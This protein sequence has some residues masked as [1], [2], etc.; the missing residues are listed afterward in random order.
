MA[1]SRKRKK[2][3]ARVKGAESQRCYR[4]RMDR[5]SQLHDEFQGYRNELV[6]RLRPTR[7]G[8]NR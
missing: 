1:R 8:T 7:S 2:E 3:A 6:R 5:A 4:K